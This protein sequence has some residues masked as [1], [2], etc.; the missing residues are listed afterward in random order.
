[1]KGKP[2]KTSMQDLADHLCIS[3]NAVSL[4]INNKPGVSEELRAKVLEAANRLNYRFTKK[5]K[6]VRNNLLILIPS[7][8]KNDR[9]FYYEL[10]WAIEQR[11]KENGYNAMICGVTPEME[12]RRTLPE[13]Y[14]EMPF[15]GIIIVGVFRLDY[16]RRLL[17]T[18]LPLVTVDHCYETLQLNAVVT[19]NEEEAYKMVRHLIDYGHRDIGFIGSIEMTRSFKDRWSGYCHAMKDAGLDIQEQYCLLQ[20]SPLEVLLGS[21]DELTAYIDGLRSMPTAWFCANDVIAI[22]MIQ[23]LQS[24]GL[25]VP[26]DI[27][28][29]GFDDI[30]SS[31]LIAPALTT[32]QVQRE[33]LGFE[34]VDFLIRQIEFGGAP[35][36]L[37]VY[38][39]LIARD[40]CTWAKK[41]D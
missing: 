9:I 17:E 27:S 5:N 1:M 37:S 11:T 19:A 25:T 35:A 39:E 13:L 2:G 29:A 31:T 32:I 8:I 28:I 40:S 16:V 34:A 18:G 30:A 6:Q 3:K 12:E 38:G 14:D 24:R 20:S 21:K 26:E 7:Y 23:I 10:F 4:A 33:Q 41:S 36:K 15:H 22:S